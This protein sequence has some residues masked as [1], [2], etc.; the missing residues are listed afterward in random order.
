MSAPG[1]QVRAQLQAAGVDP[2]AARTLTEKLTGL[3][4]GETFTERD[5]RRNRDLLRLA[6]AVR[7]QLLAER[8]ADISEEQALRVAAGL[9]IGGWEQPAWMDT[10]MQ[11]DQ[12]IGAAR[13]PKAI[14][15]CACGED[16]AEMPMVNIAPAGAAPILA[17]AVCAEHKRH[18]PCRECP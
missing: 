18:M 7:E 3:G 15:G 17:P 11:I 6:H 16:H 8:I 1:D 14:T 10:I 2:D 13:R 12:A 5:A 4:P 9:A